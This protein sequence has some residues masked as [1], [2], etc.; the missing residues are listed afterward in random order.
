[1]VI[2]FAGA[3]GNLGKLMCEALLARARMVGQDVLVCRVVRPL[4]APALP[5]VRGTAE[6]R[7]VIEPVDYMT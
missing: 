1:M 5:T 6:P 2:V 7:L 3:R 4:R